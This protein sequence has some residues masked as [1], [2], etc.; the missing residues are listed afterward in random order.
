[1]I[2]ART[3]V[4][5]ILGD[6]VAHS[7]S[8][9]MHNAAFRAAGLDACYVA[10][11]S[12]VG[13]VGDLMGALVAAGGG[14]NVTV[15]Y[16]EEAVAAVARPSVMV[17][18]VGAANTFWGDDGVVAG[19][20]TDVE[21]ILSA[22]ARLD[23]PA[24]TW[25]VI[26]TG[27]SARAVAAAAAERGAALA[28]RSRDGTRG[29]EFARWASAL[30]VAVAAPDE[31]EVVINSTP[32]G[33]KPGDAL[34]CPASAHPRARAALD[35]VYAPRGTRWIAGL[36]TAGLRAVDGREVLVAQGAAAF[37]RWF[38]KV[39]PPVEVMRAAVARALG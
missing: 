29:R 30:G 34:P 18:R 3:R 21:G 37:S 27:G 32:L 5:A 22:L 20:N 10:L 1:M 36:R 31:C 28:V 2:G 8:P 15:P 17:S 24:S 39:A 7:L 16:K 4:F 9:V 35:L 13:R 12:A 14:G 23:A 19:D 33:L 26:G 6:P 25:L 38:P 11:R